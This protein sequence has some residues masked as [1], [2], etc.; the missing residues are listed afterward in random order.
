MQTSVRSE[1]RLG[2]PGHP[3]GEPV[4]GGI[5]RTAEVA[6]RP[7]D[8]AIRGTSATGA[9]KTAKKLTAAA[10]ADPDGFKTNIGSTAGIQTFTGADFQGA[11][12]TTRMF[13]ARNVVLVLSS[14]ADWDATTAVVTGLDI[15]GREVTEN[16]TIPNAGNATVTGAVL[17]SKIISLVIP[18]Q[19][20]TGGT[21]TFGTG[22]L[23]GG[24]TSADALG[25]VRYKSAI[26]T[27]E[28][29]T[30]EFAIGDDLSIIDDG[31]KG[32]WVEVEEDV[33]DGEQAFVRLVISGDE[34]VGGL[35][36]DRD[37]TAAAP[38]A[39]PVYGM[40][41]QG[42]SETRDSVKMARVVYVFPNS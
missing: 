20:G 25:I 40:R 22:T 27:A 42:D 11:I 32:V 29:A 24:I 2:R 7:G 36:N 6:M 28:D 18:A 13:P 5:G 38:D 3:V 16:L 33:E 4:G 30:S 15:Y 1:E 34:V 17:F 26:A 19:S 9:G 10:A 21:A 23:L 8:L 39:V 14:H 31:S 41:F 35:R 37:G 12:G